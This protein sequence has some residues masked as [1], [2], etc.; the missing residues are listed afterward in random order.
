MPL[1]SRFCIA[2]LMSQCI[3]V[4]AWW[5][6][7]MTSMSFCDRFIHDQ[8]RSSLFAFAVG[9]AALLVVLPVV[10]CF[11]IARQRRWT[12]PLAWLHVGAAIYATLWA[13]S[14]LA[15]HSSLW[16]GGVLMLP[17]AAAALLVALSLGRNST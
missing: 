17:I 6:G 12:V 15:Q 3:G 9:D 1:R 10:I 16:L 4:L 13:L 8:S 5:Y 2:Y 14:M 11:G 7:L